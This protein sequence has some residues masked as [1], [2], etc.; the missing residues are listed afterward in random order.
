MNYNDW[1]T[2]KTLV[3]RIHDYKI[4]KHIVLVDNASSD[5]SYQQ[6]L[7]M[8]DEKV[9]VLLAEKNGGYG[10]GNNMGIRYSVEQ[11]GMSQIL[12]ANP[13][14]IFSEEC[15]RCLARVL[16]ARP[17]IGAA[18]AI[19]EDAVYGGQMNG[20]K[21]RG[22]GGELLSMGPVSRRVFG[23][24]LNY[25][26]KYFR[27]KK[28]VYVDAVHGSMLMVNGKAFLDCGGYDENIFLYQEEAVLGQR[29]RAGGYRMV[30][31][32]NQRYRH[33]HSVSI[34]KAYDTLTA[35]Q[36]IRNQSEMYYMERYLH[37]N[38][39]QKIAARL[40]FGGILLEDYA[41]ALLGKCLKI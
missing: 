21:L 8:K 27:G 12:I 16:E 39:W 5:D 7:R 31:L 35:R 20:W 22:F 11:L 38:S 1:P 34:S 13:D 41:A 14:V 29:M 33:E 3:E 18:S 19:V 26:E 4:L 40:W 17:D 37:I 25:P 6:L 28:A 24:F 2:V 10:S 36:R 9:T 15:V 30:L 32:L 23:R